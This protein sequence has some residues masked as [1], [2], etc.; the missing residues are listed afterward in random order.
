MQGATW[1]WLGL[2]TACG[3]TT[4]GPDDLGVGGS[5]SGHA[6]VAGGAGVVTTGGTAGSAVKELPKP[7]SCDAEVSVIIPDPL[8]N[9]RVHEALRLSM[10]APLALADVESLGSLDVEEAGSEP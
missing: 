4:R 2:I 7:K 5:A 8:L 10:T 3:A 1:A 9:A 6:G